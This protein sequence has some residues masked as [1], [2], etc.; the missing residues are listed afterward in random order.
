VADIV[1]PASDTAFLL[2]RAIADAVG[3]LWL[4]ELA[5]R[6][7][8]NF[9]EVLRSA[10]EQ[11][12]DRRRIARTFERM[13]DEVADSL[14]PVLRETTVDARDNRIVVIVADAL[15]TTAPPVD[16]DLS[17]DLD[18][19]ILERRYRQQLDDAGLE[20]VSKERAAQLIGEATDYIVALCSS[21]PALRSPHALARLRAEKELFDLTQ[22]VITALPTRSTS[23]RLGDDD[24]DT[25]YRREIVR[26]LDRLVLFGLTVAEETRRYPLNVAYISLNASQVKADEAAGQFPP[27]EAESDGDDEVVGVEDD[28]DDEVPDPRERVEL[29]VEDV[30]ASS[31]RL[32]LRGEAGS[33]KTTLLQYLAVKSGAGSFNEPLEDLN[34]SVPFL[35]QLRRYTGVPLPRPQE[36]LQHH[37]S[38]HEAQPPGWVEEQL[39]NGRALVLVD[40][41]DE[42]PSDEREDAR[43]WLRDLCQR[44]PDASYIVTSRPPAVTGDWLGEQEFR[45]AELQPMGLPDIESFIRHWHDAARQDAIDDADRLELDRL[46]TKLASAVRVSRPIRSLATSPLLCAMLC[47]LNRD[48]RSQLPGDRQELYRIALETLLDRRDVERELPASDVIGFREKQVLL[49][50]LAFWL[51]QNGRSD[52]SRQEALTRIA[53]K[54]Q[55]MP[56]VSDR[57]PRVFEFLLERSGLLRE[58]VSGRLDF[59]HRT[60]Q[61]YLAAWEAVEREA[62]E[63]LLSVAHLDE[64]REVIILAAGQARRRQREELIEGLLD[65]GDERP[66]YRSRLHLLAVACL[67]NSPELDRAVTA[68]LR[69]ALRRLVPPTSMTQARLVASAGDLAVPLL[70]QYSGSHV[71]STTAASCVRALSLIGGEQALAAMPDFANDRRVTVHREVIRGWGFFD[72]EAYS[73][74]VLADCPF[75]RGLRLQSPYS[76]KWVPYLSRLRNLEFVYPGPGETDIDLAPVAGR[77]NLDRLRIVRARPQTLAPVAALRQ[78]RTLELSA[79]SGVV[80]LDALASLDRLRRLNLF[81]VRDLH[82]VRAVRSLDELR[83]V[84]LWGAH[85]VAELE[86]LIRPQLTALT[87]TLPAHL[88][89]LDVLRGAPALTELRVDA[90]RLQRIDAVQ[91]MPELQRLLLDS[92]KGLRDLDAIAGL[93]DLFYLYIA[94]AEDLEDLDGLGRAAPPAVYIRGAHRLETLPSFSGP[95]D[96]TVLEISDAPIVDLLPI[97]RLRSLSTLILRNCTNLEDL[98][99]IASLPA[100]RELVLIG[101]SSVTD[102]TPLAKCQMLWHVDLEDCSSVRS[103][104]PLM[105]L[106]RLRSVD[107]RGVQDPIG[108]E[109]LRKRGVNVLSR[110]FP[111]ASASR[112]SGMITAPV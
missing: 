48:R 99:P 67:E 3:R 66:D 31:R 88:D 96:M 32:L 37:P 81:N 40:G 16:F 36:F 29:R 62:T 47:A 17:E 28:E 43:E 69:G 97:S 108:V 13:A 73:R 61:E 70:A 50:D 101:C 27:A 44:Y 90:E 105:E 41:V 18:P 38:L 35:L 65:L 77:R 84:S 46:Q 54:T 89:N 92:A 102:L 72:A 9:E 91:R 11:S 74:N 110:Y 75:P 68:R 58:P 79:C 87:V 34:G 109:A 6:E 53:E 80:N 76:L 4:A 26:E 19:F 98:A 30:V 85:R 59:V 78:L 55:A 104:A 106:P 23:A 10:F 86:P 107:T 111:A 49:A 82:D 112:P 25:R 15:R 5:S 100:L 71:L 60:F 51:M 95:E 7:A 2:G 39:R 21:L 24:F 64:W 12:S 14:A 42:V 56:G 94:Q 83:V 20:T 103:V 33:G 22:L 45:S 57:P 93:E 8:R 52:I 1:H 63:F